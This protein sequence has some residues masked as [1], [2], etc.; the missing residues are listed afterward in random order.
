MHAVKNVQY[1]SGYKLLLTFED[2]HV[3]LVDLAPHLEGEIFE[4]LKDPAYFKRVR[5]SED[6]DTIVW[7]NGAD[8]SPDFLYEIGTEAPKA[9]GV[10]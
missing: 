7:D 5:V 3:R 8:F 6:L 1:V 9:A 2:T 10:R 4:P